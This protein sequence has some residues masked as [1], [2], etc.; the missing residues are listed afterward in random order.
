MCDRTW[1]GRSRAAFQGR[2]GN[3]P[4]W[5]QV[6]TDF[7]FSDGSLKFCT[8]RFGAVGGGVLSGALLT[9]RLWEQ[10]GRILPTGKTGENPDLKRAV[11][12]TGAPGPGPLPPDPLPYFRISIRISAVV[13]RSAPSINLLPSSRA[14]L[15]FRQNHRN[16]SPLP[17]EP[18]LLEGEGSRRQL[19]PRA[20]H[21]TLKPSPF[22]LV[23]PRIPQPGG[24]RG[25]PRHSW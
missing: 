25:P 22:I 1:V 2:V 17:N 3:I 20:N 6:E 4:S 9:L 11:V 24:G 5:D 13:P 8:V 12:V 21:R 16:D 18:C 23:S 19:S 14:P 15:R 7:C 10:A